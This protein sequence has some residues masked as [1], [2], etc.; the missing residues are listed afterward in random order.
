MQLVLTKTE[1]K[2]GLMG[3]KTMFVLTAKV[4][5]NDEERKAIHHFRLEGAVFYKSEAEEHGP[6]QYIGADKALGLAS[7]LLFKQSAISIDGLS[8]VNGLTLENESLLHLLDLEERVKQAASLFAI[9][10]A[11]A[12][13]FLGEEKLDLPLV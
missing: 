6:R 5:I 8:L 12:I 10:T 2:R 3:G 7:R 11:K 13:T 4:A 1:A 9:V